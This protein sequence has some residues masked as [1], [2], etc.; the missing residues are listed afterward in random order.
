MSVRDV[1]MWQLLLSCFPLF[2]SLM[3]RLPTCLT[4]AKGSGTQ[5]FPHWRSQGE[6][7]TSSK[8]RQSP[9]GNRCWEVAPTKE[10]PP[11]PILLEAWRS[12]A[13]WRLFFRPGCA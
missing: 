13:S 5:G 8:G 2:F 9:E 11:T 1:L 12:L 4:C 10:D 6:W 3:P 7:G